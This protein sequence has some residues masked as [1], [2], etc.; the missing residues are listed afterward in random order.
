[1]FSQNIFNRDNDKIFLLLNYP[2]NTQYFYYKKTPTPLSSISNDTTTITCVWKRDGYYYYLDSDLK[3]RS[4][5][6]NN[7]FLVV[8]VDD[9]LFDAD[10]HHHLDDEDLGEVN[11]SA[12]IGNDR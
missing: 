11:I 5:H 10:D 4:F 7:F 8:S 12:S 2:R 1:M 6:R 3:V 9:V